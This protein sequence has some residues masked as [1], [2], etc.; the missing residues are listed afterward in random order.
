[1]HYFDTIDSTNNYAMQL[2]DDGLAQDGEIVW[3]KHQTGGKG[4]RGKT[5]MDSPDNLKCSLLLHPL[6]GASEQFQ[7]S[8]AISVTIAQYISSL[9]PGPVALKWPNDIYINDKKACGILIENV[10]RGMDWFFAVVGI[11]LN[12]NQIDFPPE[13]NRATSLKL[14]SGKDFDFLELI[15]DL[16]NGIRNSLIRLHQGASPDLS[17]QYNDLLFRKGKSVAFIETAGG[18]RFEA[19]VTEVDANGQLVLL[20]PTGIEKYKF[21]SLEWVL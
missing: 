10:F 2:V 8:M 4:Q 12:V 16:R 3:A 21:G 19:F 17:R 5:W 14:A 20:T 1:M 11:G 13:L 9:V 7:L 15:T 6:I 18:K